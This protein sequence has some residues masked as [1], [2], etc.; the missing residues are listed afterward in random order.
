MNSESLI[1]PGGLW[2]MGLYLL[3]LIGV[4]MAG[5]MARKENSLADFY[6]AGRGMGLPVLFLTLYATQ[7][8]GNTLIGFAGKAYRGGYASIVMVIFMSSVV[9][10]Y[11]I[12][13][14]KLFRMSQQHK[15][16]TIGDYIQHRFPVSII[17]L[18]NY[19]FIHDSIRELYPHQPEGNR[20]YR[21]SGNWWKSWICSKHYY[22]FVYY[23]SL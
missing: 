22:S 3:S 15:F 16:I 1:G 21:S 19:Y 12:F 2:F 10:A 6:L 11:L 13:A 7:Y 17:N 4:G 5:K 23:G 9:G 18:F 8:S 14:P 20:L